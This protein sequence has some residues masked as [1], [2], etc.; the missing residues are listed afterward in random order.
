MR[1][2]SALLLLTLSFGARAQEPAPTEKLFL[3][4]FTVGESWV[5]EKAPHEQAYFAEHSA[6]LKRLRTEG[7]LVLGGRYSDKGIIIVKAVSEEAVRAELERDP[8]VARRTFD[9]AVFPFAP[10]YDGC[11][12]RKK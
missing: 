2:L 10:F 1:I 11:I 12:E 7:K 4:Q 6:N 3:V 9:A 5:R 8:S